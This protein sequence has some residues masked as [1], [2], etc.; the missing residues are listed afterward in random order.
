MLA[1]LE[2]DLEFYFF[3]RFKSV[4]Y[5]LIPSLTMPT[6]LDRALNSKN[7]LLGFAG[8]ITAAAVWSIW[9]GDMF[10]QE[11]DPSGD[12]EEWT[13]TELKRWLNAR[14]LMPSESASRSEL[15]ERVR[16]NLRPPRRS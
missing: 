14:G 12:P 11:P 5:S 15:V 16:V 4:S 7:L 9:G 1:A 2:T 3:T 13:L 6:A 10:P 8:A